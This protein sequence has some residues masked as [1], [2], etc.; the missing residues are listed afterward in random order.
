MSTERTGRTSEGR[1]PRL[2]SPFSEAKDPCV[3]YELDAGMPLGV[4]RAR[5]ERSGLSLHCGA[6]RLRRILFPRIEPLLERRSRDRGVGARE[7]GTASRRTT[8]RGVVREFLHFQRLPSSGRP[9][10]GHIDQA[11]FLRTCDFGN[12]RGRFL[13]KVIWASTRA[14]AATATGWTSCSGT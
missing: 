4:W 2:H 3:G 12:S 8:V 13:R 6:A 9:T 11:L 7:E 5:R 10:R 1:L 14:I